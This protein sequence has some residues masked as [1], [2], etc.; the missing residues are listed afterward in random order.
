MRIHIHFSDDDQAQF[1]R[2]SDPEAVHLHVKT[3]QRRQRDSARRVSG[4]TPNSADDWVRAAH[5]GV[6]WLEGFLSSV[7]GPRGAGNFAMRK[8]PTNTRTS[9]PVAWTTQPIS[10]RSSR[11]HKFGR[12]E[13]AAIATINALYLGL[14]AAAVSVALAH[15]MPITA[16][17]VLFS[18][19]ALALCGVL[20]SGAY[21]L[22][23][24]IKGVF[25]LR[26]A[27]PWSRM[28]PIG[29]IVAILAW[30]TL[31]PWLWWYYCGHL[32]VEAFRRDPDRRQRIAFETA[33]LEADLGMVD[34]PLAG[35]CTTCDRPLVADAPFCAFCGAETQPR[36]KICPTCATHAPVDARFCPQCRTMLD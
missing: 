10:R 31:F 16:S 11:F 35:T 3:P 32:V 17:I 24:D 6:T 23:V 21:A 5:L 2:D 8:M 1:G 9:R 33:R 22:S 13:V 25:A 30:L 12:G 19:T 36:P 20:I 26:G 34:I 29:W 15:I 18:S 27:I 4:R 7:R 14:Q 28:S